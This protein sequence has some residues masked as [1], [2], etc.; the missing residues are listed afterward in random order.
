M[1]E[2]L[3]GGRRVAAHRRSLRKGGFTTQA[4]HRPKAHQQYLEWTPSRIIAWASKTGPRTG[5]LVQRILESKPHPEQGYRSCLGLLRLG[6]TYSPAR[7]EAACNRALRIGGVSYRSVK[8]IL[9]SGLDQMPLVEQV[10]LRLPQNHEHV[11]GGAYYA[12]DSTQG[13]PPC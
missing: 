12:Q 8:S 7:L 9:Q 1:V 10:T 4:A 3:H 13:E 11:R 5:E 6:Q 2:I